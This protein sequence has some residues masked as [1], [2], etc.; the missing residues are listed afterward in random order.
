MMKTCSN[1]ESQN[2]DEAKFCNVCG[3]DLQNIESVQLQ[4]NDYQ[5]DVT[6]QQYDNQTYDTQNLQQTSNQ[7]QYNNSQSAYQNNYKP[8]NQKNVIIAVILDIVLGF[9]LYFLCGVGQLYLGLYKRGVVLGAL[10]FVPM[11]IGSILIYSGNVGLGTI[12]SLVLGIIL[13]IYA[14]YDAYVCTAAINEG[15]PIPLLLGNFDIQ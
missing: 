14:A 3:N 12:I 15:R 2:P 4:Q 7:Q 13:I 9:I 11:I 6:Q 8:T 1:C 5:S 10:G